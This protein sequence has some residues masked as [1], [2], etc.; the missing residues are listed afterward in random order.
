MPDRCACRSTNGHCTA[1]PPFAQHND[2]VIGQVQQSCR[3]VV[4]RSHVGVIQ[5]GQLGQAQSAGIKQFEH[6]LIA[7]CNRLVGDRGSG[8]VQQGHGLLYR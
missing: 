5:A 6:G 3:G 1:F 2:F 4:V 8:P 7:Q